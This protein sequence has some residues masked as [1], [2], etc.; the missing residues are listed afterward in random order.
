MM[1]ATRVLA[2]GRVASIL[3]VWTYNPCKRCQALLVSLLGL[4]KSAQR[5]RPG[6]QRQRP[7]AY[8][9]RS[10]RYRRCA[11]RMQQA[12]SKLFE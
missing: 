4:D 8:R 11:A 10:Q 6:D 2:L 7:A 12:K 9:W 5:L 3:P 1:T